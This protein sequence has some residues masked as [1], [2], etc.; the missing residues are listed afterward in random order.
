MLESQDKYNS[1]DIQ[2][3]I[4][5]ASKIINAQQLEYAPRTNET[6][7]HFLER[8]RMYQEIA[9]NKNWRTHVDNGRKVWH[10]HKLPGGCFMCEDTQMITVLIHIITIISLKDPEGHF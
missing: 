1:M 8:I 4:F 5:E 7:V 2:G 3:E 10:T 6:Y 9:H